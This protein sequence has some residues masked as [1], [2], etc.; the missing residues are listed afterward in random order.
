MIPVRQGFVRPVVKDL[1]ASTAEA[2]AQVIPDPFVVRGKV[3]G[4]TAPSRGIRD[5]GL[6][7]RHLVETLRLF[8]AIPKVLTAMGTHGGGTAE[9]NLETA[10]IAVS[11]RNGSGPRSSAT[12]RRPIS[13]PSTESR[14]TLG[15]PRWRATG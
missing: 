2:L 7:L 9:G 1:A 8:G 6:V 12:S 14:F 13:I 11:I 15:E 4:L 10:Q 5:I 3:I